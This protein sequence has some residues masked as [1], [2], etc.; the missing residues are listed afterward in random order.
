M[1]IR[2]LSFTLILGL[3]AAPII[4]SPTVSD[5]KRSGDSEDSILSSSVH[6]PNYY[7]PLVDLL[8]PS[9]WDLNVPGGPGDMDQVIYLRSPRHI[10]DK[11]DLD[12][13]EQILFRP[14]FRHRQLLAERT[15]RLKDKDSL[16][17]RL[18]SVD[19]SPQFLARDSFSRRKRSLQAL[20]Y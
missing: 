13:A 15:Q 12:T 3:V 20:S 1:S 8:S 10:D 18:F 4:A 17:R 11:E 9:P 16:R 14:L 2:R 7:S 5:T 19:T 6:S